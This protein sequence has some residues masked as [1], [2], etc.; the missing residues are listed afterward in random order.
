MKKMI[1]AWSTLCVVGVLSLGLS[2]ARG[3]VLVEDF[4]ESVWS[5]NGYAKRTVVASSG[6]W[7]VAGV[8]QMDAG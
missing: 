5:N 2:E 7:T 1:N 3:K 8:G 4:E 6:T